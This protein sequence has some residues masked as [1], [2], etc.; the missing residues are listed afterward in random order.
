[1]VRE[2]RRNAGLIAFFQYILIIDSDKD[3][4][5]TQKSIL[6]YSPHGMNQ[7]CLKTPG[8]TALITSKKCYVITEL[9]F[10]YHMLEFTVA[11]ESKFRKHL[12]QTRFVFSTESF[13]WSQI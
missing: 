1:M 9:S 4:N 3:K 5:S 7:K 2:R 10:E 11:V 8:P 6:L 13:L 12:H